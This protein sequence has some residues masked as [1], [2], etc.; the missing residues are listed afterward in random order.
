VR[1][2]LNICRA[3][4]SRRDSDAQ[5]NDSEISKFLHRLKASGHQISD[6]EDES[7]VS[8]AHYFSKEYFDCGA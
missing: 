8:K 1:L 3:G 7:D 2:K 6:E 4:H 5:E